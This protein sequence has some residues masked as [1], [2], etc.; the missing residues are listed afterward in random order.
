MTFQSFDSFEE[1]AKHIREAEDAANER[2]KPYQQDIV[3]GSHWVAG[4]VDL[5]LVVFGEVM[6]LE[7]M[8]KA[9]REAGADDEE[10]A[11]TKETTLDSYARGYRFGYCYSVVEPEGELGSTHISQMVPISKTQFEQARESGWTWPW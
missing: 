6:T 11:F 2:V 9:E 7:V 8:E 3:W 5:E 1:M 10:W 4:Y